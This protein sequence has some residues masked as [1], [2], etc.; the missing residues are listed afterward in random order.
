[1]SRSARSRNAIRAVASRRH[2][3]RFRPS[4]CGQSRTK[5]RP[6]STA[7][8]VITKKPKSRRSNLLI[9]PV[10]WRVPH[11]GSATRVAEQGPGPRLL[12]AI[13]L[14]STAENASEMN[15]GSS[16]PESRRAFR[17][18]VSVHEQPALAQRAAMTA[19]A[20]EPFP[21]LST[22]MAVKT[23]CSRSTTSTSA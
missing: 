17:S 11:L 20:N 13:S 21:C 5:P 3:A 7:N 6:F 16:K 14:D 9:V 22:I 4:R 15:Q 12:E 8:A 2:R 19:S 1:M 18:N 23:S 10:S